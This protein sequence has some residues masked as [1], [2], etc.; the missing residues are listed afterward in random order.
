MANDGEQ[1]PRARAGL[2]APFRFY[3]ARTRFV[4]EPNPL[5]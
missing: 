5:A 3:V 2:A 1:L 4:I